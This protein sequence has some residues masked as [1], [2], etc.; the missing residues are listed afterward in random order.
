[1]PYLFKCALGIE[2]IEN[3]ISR[4]TDEW[5]HP[6][7]VAQDSSPRW[8]VVVEQPDLGGEGQETDDD[9]LGKR[10]EMNRHQDT[11]GTVILRKRY[12]CHLY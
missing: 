7:A 10:S 1:M 8:V 11:H 5:G 12:G 3:H 9:E 6:D 2:Q 4:H